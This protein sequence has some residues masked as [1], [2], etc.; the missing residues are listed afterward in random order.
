MQQGEGGALMT[1]RDDI[2]TAIKAA[3]ENYRAGL[4]HLYSLSGRSCS[5]GFEGGYRAGM[6][7]LDTVRAEASADAVLEVLDRLGDGAPQ[8]E[9][10]ERGRD[11]TVT[12]Y[13][14]P[15]ITVRE[16]HRRAMRGEL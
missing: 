13:P 11:I 7:H 9:A 1:L 3:Q 10:A 5:C 12:I 16:A 2:V 4:A 15:M 8:G 6:D 14:E